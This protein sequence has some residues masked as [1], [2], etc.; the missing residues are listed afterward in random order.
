MSLFIVG[1]IVLMLS[2]MISNDSM[3]Y[4]SIVGY[5]LVALSILLI[6]VSIFNNVLKISGGKL[7]SFIPLFFNNTG[8]FILNMGVILFLLS[9][10]IIY[11][12]R[13]SAGNLSDS[14]YSFSL[15]SAFLVLI[16]VIIFYYGMNTKT[17]RDEKKLPVI[18][19]SFSYLV[20]VINLYISVIIQI[21]L[22][23]YTTDG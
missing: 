17:Y 1:S 7:S 14:Y 10:M 13:I 22:K 12:K 16:Q 6:T 21:I 20:G 4:V 5:C 15:F 18:Y 19:G 3:V 23:Y 9:L 11:K 8:P 2:F